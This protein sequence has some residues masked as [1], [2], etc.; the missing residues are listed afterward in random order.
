M[1]YRIRIVK[2]EEVEK[3]EQEYQLISET[4]NERDNGKV[5][6]YVPY[7]KIKN[8]ETEV[9][10]LETENLDITKVAKAVLIDGMN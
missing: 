3:T 7:K 10:N 4:G 2:I 8:V 6:G 9:L 1:K 5:W